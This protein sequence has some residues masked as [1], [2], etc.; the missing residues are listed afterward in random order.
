MSEISINIRIP[1]FIYS[2]CDELANM[3]CYD[4]AEQYIA[5]LVTMNAFKQCRIMNG[6]TI[7]D[8]SVYDV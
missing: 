6:E 7:E 2:I 8:Y 4:S 1:A 5:K 3:R